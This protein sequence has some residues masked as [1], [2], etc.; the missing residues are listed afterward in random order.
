MRGISEISLCNQLHTVTAA[1][2][3]YHTRCPKH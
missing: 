2:K 1:T 3:W